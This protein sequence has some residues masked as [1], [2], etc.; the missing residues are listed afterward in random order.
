ME[1]LEDTLLGMFLPATSRS[2]RKQQL[3]APKFYLFDIGIKNTLD[4]AITRTRL[5]SQEVGVAFEHFI[6]GECH[7]LNGYKR[8]G[9]RFSYLRTKGGLEIDL[10]AE[11]PHGVPIFIEI[12]ATDNVQPQH[13]EHLRAVKRDHQEIR[14]LCLCQERQARLVDGVEILPWQEALT[15]LFG[16]R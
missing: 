4:G 11:K 15:E 10:V 14:T 6:I 2:I 1:V 16:G 5:S 7:R 9:Y 3:E 12:K 8:S 13:L